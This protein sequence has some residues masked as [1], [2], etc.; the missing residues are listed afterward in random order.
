MKAEMCMSPVLLDNLKLW[1][2]RVA[3]VYVL[4]VGAG[5]TETDRTEQQ[6]KQSNGHQE[7]I[8]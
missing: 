3:V 8:N 5:K 4:G 6:N 1:T 2:D 7:F